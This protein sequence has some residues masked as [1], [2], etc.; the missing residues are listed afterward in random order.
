MCCP[1]L[2]HTAGNDN[3]LAWCNGGMVITRDKPKKF[4]IILQRLQDHRMR[5]E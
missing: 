3:R 4:L 5:D 1:R 2:S